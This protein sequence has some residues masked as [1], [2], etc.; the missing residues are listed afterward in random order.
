[1]AIE[2]PS[3]ATDR[4]A[5]PDW[6]T[7]VSMGRYTLSASR[8]SAVLDPTS[9]P[10]S[11]LDAL[12]ALAA[13][14]ASVAVYIA[15]DRGLVQILVDG[16]R[17]PLSGDARDAV[18]NLLGEA[19]RSSLAPGGSGAGPTGA[20]LFDS[21]DA[22]RIAI[23]DAQ[24]QE[25]RAHG[26]DANPSVLEP[27][28]GRLATVITAPLMGDPAAD[29]AGKSLERA[30]DSSSGLFLEAHLA[31]W[32]RGER[33]LSQIQDE[34]LA[35]PAAARAGDAASS[36]RRAAAQ[37]DALQRQA[38][39]LT[40]QAWAG[41][42]VQ[43]EI[44]RDRERHREAA[45]LGDATGLFQATLTLHLPRLGTLRARIRIMEGTVGLQIESDRTSALAP[46]LQQLATAL[47]ARGL[48]VA[49]LA[50]APAAPRPPPSDGN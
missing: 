32:L 1:V 20:T 49:A 22:A 37:I 36:D 14:G 41:Q 46:E 35:L 7:T 6:G 30:I 28:P 23:V 26:P 9:A 33:S 5:R 2:I 21:S 34:V 8:L 40:A 45:N 29:D 11:L 43:I 18:L 42:P 16:R 17:V 13:K 44:E 24:I 48:N 39:N 50:L 4:L 15:P 19:A 3:P 47:S 38:I 10:A 31:Q 27:L 25:S 12:R